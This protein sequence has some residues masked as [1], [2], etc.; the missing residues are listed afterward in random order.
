MYGQG[1][2]S[3]EDRFRG[4]LFFVADF[5]VLYVNIYIFTYIVAY[6][7]KMWMLA[8]YMFIQNILMFN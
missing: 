4:W 5:S 2:Q 3:G 1:G 8:E 6:L 7:H